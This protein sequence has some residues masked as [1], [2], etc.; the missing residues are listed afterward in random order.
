MSET[1]TLEHVCPKCGKAFATSN[2]LGG[3]LSAAHRKTPAPGAAVNRAKAAEPP[4]DF[5]HRARLVALQR[6]AAEPF[7][8]ELADVEQRLKAVNAERDELMHLRTELHVVLRKLDPDTAIK[9]SVS[10][11]GGNAARQVRNEQLR[12]DAIRDYLTDHPE[13]AAAGFTMSVVIE[14]LKRSG[15]LSMTTGSAAGAFDRLRDEG[16]IRADRVTRGG[17][18]QYV[19]VTNHDGGTNGTQT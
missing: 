3:H 11:S 5:T 8:V 6:D 12:V 4:R 16:F 13:E 7:R 2:A 9:R 17:G 15:G 19:L 18:M 10:K 14:G 1:A